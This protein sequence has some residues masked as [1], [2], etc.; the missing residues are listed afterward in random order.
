MIL[1]FFKYLISAYIPFGEYF[2]LFPIII[3]V[4][5]NIITRYYDKITIYLLIFNFFFIFLF[6]ISLIND[7]NVKIA[8]IGLLNYTLTLNFWILYLKNNLSSFNRIRNLLYSF[9]F[10]ISLAGIVQ[11]FI[12][13]KIFG[14]INYS[15]FSDEKNLKKIV[16]SKRAISII[17]SPQTLG[18]VLSIYI[19]YS[20]KKKLMLINY[21]T[22]VLTFTKSFFLSIFLDYFLRFRIKYIGLILALTSLFLWVIYRFQEISG[23]SRLYNFIFYFKF[24]SQVD[25]I[26]R[27]NYYLNMLDSPSKLAFGN[28][29]GIAS[30]ANGLI[31]SN[32]L[33]YSSESF[34]IQ[35]F[36]EAGLLGLLLFVLPFI[37]LLLKD[38]KQ[39]SKII[40]LFTLMLLSPAFYGFSVSFLI[41]PLILIPFFL[42]YRE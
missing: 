12:D 22:G 29:L 6:A 15:I 3:Y 2:Y 8:S 28:G 39:R 13:P 34:L 38:K 11:Y 24:N 4:C 14:L 32:P 41:Y 42:N 19:L 27:W 16:F 40:V 26:D 5:T 10:L 35:I 25:R 7:V 37:L 9:I 18:F 21:I 1:Y 31:L 30:R 23:I 33:N 17:K 20:K 36:T